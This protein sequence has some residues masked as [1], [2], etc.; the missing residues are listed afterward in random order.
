[1]PFAGRCGN[2][3]A[4]DGETGLNPLGSFPGFDQP[5]C[6]FTET[7]SRCEAF[8]LCLVIPMP[9]SR[10]WSC[11]EWVPEVLNINGPGIKRIQY[12]GIGLHGAMRKL[13]GAGG[14]LATTMI[15][16]SPRTLFVVRATA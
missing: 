9:E 8:V 1:M 11:L 10:L 15:D 2:F 3:L 13:A 7:V 16:G 5:R 6:G 14:R 12:F 4:I